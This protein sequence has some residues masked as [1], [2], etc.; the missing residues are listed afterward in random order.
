MPFPIARETKRALKL[1]PE[2]LASVAGVSLSTAKRWKRNGVIP[3]RSKGFLNANMIV[4]AVPI[5]RM[6]PERSTS[7]YSGRFTMGY[8]VLWQYP[9]DGQ[10]LDETSIRSI[11]DLLA[12][13]RR[14]RAPGLSYQATF[15]VNSILASHQKIRQSY[16]TVEMNDGETTLMLPSTANASISDLI[17]ESSKLLHE[18]SKYITKVNN[19]RLIVRR[20]KE[21]SL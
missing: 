13:G 15:E 21:G 17:A 5:V 16:Q 9:E 11:L 20:K 8:V 18:A 6:K 12:T 1:A 19:F 10:E 3:E 7:N 14:Y 2:A 4:E